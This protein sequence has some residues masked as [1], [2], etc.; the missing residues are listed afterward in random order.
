ML[1][2]I[3]IILSLWILPSAVGLNETGRFSY[4]TIPA[5]VLHSGRCGVTVIWASRCFVYPHTNIPRDK[6][7]PGGDTYNTRS[8]RMQYSKYEQEESHLSVPLFSGIKYL[9]FYSY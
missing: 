3:F 5:P 1:L 6:S 2:L 8:E 9:R 4:K 7:T